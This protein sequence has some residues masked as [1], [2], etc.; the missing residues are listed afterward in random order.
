MRNGLMKTKLLVGGCLL[1]LTMTLATP[2]ALGLPGDDTATTEDVLVMNDRRELHGQILEENRD[3]V[4][5][6]VSISGITSRVT[7]QKS[8]IAN[9][10]RDQPI[11]DRDDSAAKPGD[12]K[13]ATTSPDDEEEDEGTFGALAGASDDESL[14]SF[15]IIPMK[16]QVGTDI[17]LEVYEMMIE[18]I[19]AVDPDYIV[20]KI[21][22]A[23]IGEG[24]Y[25]EAML[26]PE[27][28][29]LTGPNMIDMY[30]DIV[31]LFH[32]DLRDID[33]VAWVV[34][35]VGISTVLALSWDDLF[36]DSN[37]RFGGLRNAAGMFE[38]V[39]A[40][41]N[42]Y[43][44]YREAYMAWLRGLMLNSNR[45]PK[46]VDAMVI[47]EKKLAATWKGREVEWSLE[48]EGDYLVDGSEGATVNFTAQ[49]AEN[50]CLS[51]GTA[52][53]LDDVALLLGVR[54]YRVNESRGEEIF[55][56]HLED[57]RK[58]FEASIDAWNDHN[59]ALADPS[60]DAAARLGKA[61]R[62][63]E[64]MLRNLRRYDAVAVRLGFKGVSEVMLQ[65]RIET[66]EEQLRA[67]RGNERNRRGRRGGSGGGGLGG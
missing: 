24:L 22:C 19:R 10:D 20:I 48:G 50:F 37:A 53:G 5:F 64:K 54:E 12:R 25:A 41:A 62:Q 28:G 3:L 2:I 6:E 65:V 67:L 35:S 42:K 15:Y 34:D 47:N 43:G 59:E 40:D 33:Q 49:T 31:N 56:K 16:G 27:E 29:G 8:D 51:K 61:K 23:D 45:D 26:D 57:W 63:L 21:E 11:Q 52:D 9:I 58:A 66:F 17:N 60:L 55:D 39:R 30:R 1:G 14:P 7:Y 44:K 46:L 13:I 32:D 36:M 18:D 38:S 4:I